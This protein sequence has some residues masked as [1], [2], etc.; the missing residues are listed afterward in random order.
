MKYP[1][2]HS[3][4]NHT[5][6]VCVCLLSTTMGGQLEHGKG[7]QNG[8]FM[9]INRVDSYFRTRVQVPTLFMSKVHF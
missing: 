1:I 7:I 4:Y 9:D 8:L 6:S 3:D 2:Y 5:G